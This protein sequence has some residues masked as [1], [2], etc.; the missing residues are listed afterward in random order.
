[1]PYS[2]TT[3]VDGVTPVNAAN[4]NKLEVGLQNAVGVPADTVVAFNAFLLR[5]ELQAADTQPAFRLMGDGKIEW[6]V[7]GST[8]PDTALYRYG[9]G[10]LKTDGLLNA[11]QFV[12]NPTGGQVGWHSNPA[13]P[14]NYMLY[15]QVQ[16]D[17]H[18]RLTIDG[19]GGITWGSGAAAGDTVLYRQ[20]PDTLYTPDNMMVGNALSFLA[21]YTGTGT[22]FMN[23]GG[24]I[25]WGPGDW[26]RD[27]TL[28]RT[29]M[30]ELTLQGGFISTGASTV[31]GLTGLV[32]LYYRPATAVGYPIA[33]RVGA[34][35]NSR[36]HVNYLGQM[37][38]GA[39]TTG[40][41]T[42]LDRVGAN[43][44]STPGSFSIGNGA[45]ITGPLNLQ[46]GSYIYHGAM[47]AGNGVLLSRASGDADNRFTLSNTGHMYWGDG[48]AAPD[49]QMRRYVAGILGIEGGM[50]LTSDILWDATAA[51]SALLKSVV[52]GGSAYNFTL[53]ANGTLYWG[54]GDAAQ[55]TNLYRAT[56]NVLQT[57]DTF[58]AGGQLGANFASAYQIMLGTDDTFRTYAQLESVHAVAG[59]AILQ[60]AVQAEPNYRFI[61]GQN[62]ELTWGTG[63]VAGDTNLYRAAAGVLKTDGALAVAGAIGTAFP[64]SPTDGQMFTLVDSLTAPTYAWQ[65]R[66]VAG[67]AD[68]YKWL[69]IGGSAKHV[70]I[71]TSEST[72]STS[73]ANL[74][75]D[76][77][78]FTTPYAGDWSISL[79]CGAYY[80]GNTQAINLGISVGGNVDPVRVVSA[81]VGAANALG[82]LA[83]DHRASALAASSIIKARYKVSAGTHSYGGA[84]AGFISGR[85]LFVTPIRL[86]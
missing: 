49:L 42:F 68:A 84:E 7:G 78:S 22:F 48:T 65:F 34:E 74:A 15:H 61:I 14:A 19:T 63:G 20:G 8:V 33:S 6:G 16:G 35:P 56:A 72:A 46:T 57:D 59:G 66:Y 3:W 1:M 12:S 43:H 73:W 52:P 70:V 67:I 25:E 50:R 41:D 21:A 47:A 38:W 17:A 76:G 18:P 86:G 54:P 26:T 5:N 75:T 71:A 9:V 80:T 27:T 51:G 85:H 62:G 58:V 10:A 11:A 29:N 37:A 79:R 69:F 83:V 82:P 64:G 36:W 39:G 23:S 31:G 60:A 81:Q 24:S 44:L 53:T 2:P 55:D 45:Y 13:S 32:G 28:L 40:V 77:P 30:G 4:L